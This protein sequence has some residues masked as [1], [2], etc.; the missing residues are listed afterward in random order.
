ML[1]RLLGKEEAAQKGAWTTPFT[2]VP[3]WAKPYVGYAYANGLTEGISNTLFGS[4]EL[5]T[6]SQ[7]LTFVLRALGYE[8]D[9]DF[10]WD[11]AWELSD[12]IGLTEGE[13]TGEGEFLRGD[14][15]IISYNTPRSMRRW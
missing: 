7:Y 12:K 15:A 13:Y 6:V 5:V 1:V 3:N 10:K 8:S 14:L 4:Q 9:R 11:T 2:D